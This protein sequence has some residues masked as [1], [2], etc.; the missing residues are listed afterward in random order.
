[1]SP[2]NTHPHSSS[3]LVTALCPQWTRPNTPKCT[4]GACNLCRFIMNLCALDLSEYLTPTQPSLSEYSNLS[5]NNLW[6]KGSLLTHPSLIIPPHFDYLS[7]PRILSPHHSSV[8]SCRRVRSRDGTDTIF[9]PFPFWRL[10]FLF[11]YFHATD[12]AAFFLKTSWCFPPCHCALLSLFAHARLALNLSFSTS[13][14]S[15]NSGSLT[16]WSHPHVVEELSYSAQ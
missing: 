8:L 15:A 13:A 5:E 9:S 6:K 4:W 10:S 2:F 12:T 1:M 16:F 14:F 7:H 3:L 11:Y